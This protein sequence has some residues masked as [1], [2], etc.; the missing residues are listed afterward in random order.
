MNAKEIVVF[1]TG[2]TIGMDASPDLP[3]AAPGNNQGRI[4]N[5]LADVQ[6]N[7][8]IRTIAWADMPSPHISPEI[9]L[10]LS[11]DLD[12]QLSRP[13]V[14]GAVVLHGT[15]LMAETAF[16]LE[17]ALISPKPVVLTGAMLHLAQTGYDGMRN[18]EDSLAVCLAAGQGRGVLIQMAGEIFQAR[19]AVKMDSTAMNPMLAQRRGHAGRV[20]DKE[21]V[22]FQASTL[23][24]QVRALLPKPVAGLAEQ[25][26][27]IKCFPGMSAGCLNYLVDS[28]IRGLVLEGFGAGNVPPTLADALKA[29]LAQGVIVILT[30]RCLYGGV[31]PIYAYSGGGAQLVAAGLINGHGLTSDKAL[32]LLKIALGCGCN[33]KT[34]ADLCAYYG[35]L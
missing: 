13:E 7:I 22:F 9:M 20:V 8:H 29:A 33:S 19:D 4:F 18:L 28:G 11:Q 16:F 2:G 34:I 14:A 23:D 12:A 6:T 31:H 25:V 32:L 30:T 27:V 24:A 3:G 5:A 10:R 1:F 21:V 35:R 17:L 26:E 15:D